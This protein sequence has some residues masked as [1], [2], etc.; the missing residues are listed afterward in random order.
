MLRL[1][2]VASFALVLGV[3]S[4]RAADEDIAM[5]TRQIEAGTLKG[6]ALTDAY[7]ER[8]TRRMVAK[9]LDGALADFDQAVAAAP[10]LPGAY[11]DR[12]FGRS[13]AG[14]VQR[15]IDDLSEAIALG[16]DDPAAGYYLRAELHAKMKDFKGALADYDQAIALDKGFGHAYIGRGKARLETG[17]Y[18]GALADLNHA[19]NGKGKLYQYQNAF[20]L[21]PH[22]EVVITKVFGGK[23]MRLV[24]PSKVPPSAYLARGRVWLAMGDYEQARPDLNRAVEEDFKNPEVWI[25]RG[26]ENLALNRCWNGEDD[27]EEAA[28]LLGKE[29]AE[30]LQAHRDFIVK[31][32]CAKDVL[33]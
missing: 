3:S 4:S 23:G 8:G 6:A 11:V 12:S 28:V 24:S 19:I 26:L 5:L 25:Y 32:P 15:A 2:F 7:R 10:K 9:D 33:Q 22:L 20:R 16:L 31:T 30:L 1:M 29:E 14:N 27:L 21:A 17:D 13:E 18:A